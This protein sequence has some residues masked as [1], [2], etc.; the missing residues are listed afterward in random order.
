MSEIINDCADWQWNVNSWSK[1]DS[2]AA[3]IN[4]FL[5]RQHTR[6]TQHADR[7]FAWLCYGQRGDA[8]AVAAYRACRDSLGDEGLFAAVLKAHGHRKADLEEAAVHLEWQA[9]NH[10]LSLTTGWQ[11]WQAGAGATVEAMFQ[12]L[13]GQSHNGSACQLYR[14]CFD[15]DLPAF[16][17]V[18]GSH[19]ALLKTGGHDHPYLHG[20]IPDASV[21]RDQVPTAEG[22]RTSRGEH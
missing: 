1:Q 4:H 2:P 20:T 5:A 22:G 8:A 9:H 21:L 12:I 16:F 11:A 19:V 15:E 18:V 14:A 10:P 6:A 7:P 3:A 13:H 17:E